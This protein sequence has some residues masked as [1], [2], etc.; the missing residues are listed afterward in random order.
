MAW[1]QT[2]KSYFIEFYGFSK[3]FI[4]KS[5]TEQTAWSWFQHVIIP[6]GVGGIATLAILHE[7]STNRELVGEQI[8][9]SERVLQATLEAQQKLNYQQT[10]QS[11]LEQILSLTN[12]QDLSSLSSEEPI[13]KSTSAVTISTLN[14]LGAEEKRSIFDLLYELRLI[15]RDN[16]TV[17]LNDANFSGLDL[18][19]SGLS[20]PVHMQMPTE[21]KSSLYPFWGF[22]SPPL[23]ESYSGVPQHFSSYKLAGNI[24]NYIAK[25]FDAIFYCGDT[26]YPN[27]MDSV[28]LNKRCAHESKLINE[29][30]K[31]EYHKIDLDNV[32]LTEANLEHSNLISTKLGETNLTEANIRYSYL[33]GS[34]L[35]SANLDGAKLDRSNLD[36]TDLDNASFRDAS[37]SGVSMA[38]T[39]A[40][41]ADFTSADISSSKLVGADLRNSFSHSKPI[42]RSLRNLLS[43]D[44]ENSGEATFFSNAILRKA[45]L[46]GS[47]FSYTSF[48]S[49]DIRRADLSEASFSNSIFTKA[50]LSGSVLENVRFSASSLRFSSFEYSNLENAVLDGIFEGKVFFSGASLKGAKVLNSDL[51]NSNFRNSNL[52]GVELENTNLSDSNFSK[53]NLKDIQFNGV[54]L[55]FSDLRHASNLDVNIL[56]EKAKFVPSASKF[57][58]TKMEQ[59]VVICFTKLPEESS[60]SPYR[61]CLGKFRWQIRVLVIVSGAFLCL[62]LNKKGYW[63]FNQ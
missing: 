47:S 40:R 52:S 10:L 59:G 30:N 17:V 14:L 29:L 11:Y 28:N 53:A 48:Y 36:Y 46:N 43:K 61:D 33:V 2:L 55:S 15:K 3:R 9:E 8:G 27:P 13:S 50:D 34:D 56:Q 26:G 62:F 19:D 37:L 1:K 57:L 6:V 18:R 42:R 41:S 49:A 20:I 60:I 22:E 54:D 32:N 7:I 21:E 63:P 24:S 35:E 45:R 58:G 31:S 51:N 38:F 4:P 25:D 5:F 16:P 39:E 12:N 44:S 23:H